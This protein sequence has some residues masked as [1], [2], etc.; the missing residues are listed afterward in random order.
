MFAPV[1]RSSWRWLLRRQTSLLRLQQLDQ[2]D[3]VV[4]DEFG[5]LKVPGLR[6]HDVFGKLEHVGWQAQ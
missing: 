3:F 6:I 5:R 2:L 4:V 1:G